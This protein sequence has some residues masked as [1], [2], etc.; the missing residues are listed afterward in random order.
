MLPP[1]RSC[2]QKF[3]CLFCYI[4]PGHWRGLAAQL[5]TAGA[6]KERCQSA[7][8]TGEGGQRPS[9]GPL[10]LAVVDL[11]AC[12]FRALFSP[13]SFYQSFVVKKVALAL[14]EYC[15]AC[16]RSVECVP[17]VLI[18]EAAMMNLS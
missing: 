6:G 3:A 7:A 17:G 16:E 8:A 14:C 1:L 5:R 2:V 18:A 12:T 11:V 9:S 13:K 10:W 15:V 4:H